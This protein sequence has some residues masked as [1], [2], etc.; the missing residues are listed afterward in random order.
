[1]EDAAE[2]VAAIE[3]INGYLARE[4]IADA[5]E[6]EPHS[7]GCASCSAKLLKMQLDGIANNL[8]NPRLAPTLTNKVRV[9]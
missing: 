6:K 7:L 5:C 9:V 2:I 1:M 8:G 4:W 3:V